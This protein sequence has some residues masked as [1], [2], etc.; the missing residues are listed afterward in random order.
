MRWSL[1]LTLLLISFAGCLGD[2]ADNQPLDEVEMAEPETIPEPITGS[3]STPF[4]AVINTQFTGGDYNI[5]HDFRVPSN[6]THLYV[7]A[8]MDAVGPCPMIVDLLDPNGNAIALN[9]N[10]ERKIA[11][12]APGS[13]S[14]GYR[15]SS[16]CA[17]GTWHTQWTI[18]FMPHDEEADDGH[19]HA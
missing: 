1:V 4:A 12:P 3:D 18:D 5:N 7:T 8:G 13:Y 14:V 2:D 10:E 15:P 19:E 16:G 9:I 6:A 17:A 11:N